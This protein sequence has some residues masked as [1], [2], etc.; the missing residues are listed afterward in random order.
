MHRTH[1]SNGKPGIKYHHCSTHSYHDLELCHLPVPKT[2]KDLIAAKLQEGVAVEQIL[3]DIRDNLL[4]NH[5]GRDQLVTRQDIMNVQRRLNIDAVQKDAND[6][7]SVCAWVRELQCLQY[8]PV[9]IFKPQG[10]AATAEC[11]A[12]Q[13]DDFLLAVCMIVVKQ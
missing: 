12:L 7:L 2:T 5:V 3:N 1:K 11:S 9:L 6:F 10:E 13:K 4:N 8:N